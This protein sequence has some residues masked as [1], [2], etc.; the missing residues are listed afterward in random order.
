MAAAT[1]L[2]LLTESLYL[3]SGEAKPAP[4]ALPGTAKHSGKGP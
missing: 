2:Q 4:S 1:E 3:G